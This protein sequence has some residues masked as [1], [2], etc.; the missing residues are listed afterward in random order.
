MDN[1]SDKTTAHTGLCHRVILES[2]DSSHESTDSFALK[3]SMKTGVTL[4]LARHVVSQV[5]CTVKSGL[6]AA[7]ADTLK[8]VLESIGGRVR[9]ETHHVTSGETLD[10][11]S[12]LRSGGTGTQ[13]TIV[14]PRCGWEE[15]RW[16]T[17]C[18][19]C[20]RRF[21]D[22]WAKP[23]TLTDRLP[24]ENPLITQNVVPTNP[25]TRALV[26]VRRCRLPILLGIIALVVILVLK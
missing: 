19:L 6:T 3:L 9:S 22:Q 12:D 23:V 8:N 26:F 24:E 14:C 1:S 5:P 7:Q 15:G 4:P 11:R 20:L 16:A 18:S 17:H 13:A 10:V 25:W 2:I 21:R